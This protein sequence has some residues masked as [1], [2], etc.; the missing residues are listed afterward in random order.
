MSLG[1]LVKR[2]IYLKPLHYYSVAKYSS[3][4]NIY[5]RLE[6]KMPSKPL[7]LINS[8]PQ[9]EIRSEVVTEAKLEAK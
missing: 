8:G 2:K 9:C 3:K 5:I 7:Q 6:E 4:S 1:P